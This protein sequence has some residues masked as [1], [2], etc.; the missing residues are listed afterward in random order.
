MIFTGFSRAVESAD[1][2]ARVSGLLET[3]EFEPS[4]PVKAGKL[5]FTIEKKHYQAARDSAFAAL[6]SAEADLQRAET[7]L[8]RVEQAIKTH[9]I[10][11]VDVDRAR[12]ARAMADSAVKSA[13]AALDQAE[14]DL[15][16][17][18]VVSP[19][20]GFVSRNLVDAGNVVGESGLTLLTRVNKLQPIH[21]YFNAPES[22]VLRYL[23]YMKEKEKRSDED[24]EYKG[25]ARVALA[26]DEGFPHKGEIDFIDNQVNPDTGTIEMRI[27]LENEDLVLF[28]GLFVRVKLSGMELP[29]AV[30][31]PETA[32]GTDLGGKYVLLVGENNI[33]EQRYVELGLPQDGGMV[34]VE[35]GLEGDET[36]IVNGLMFARPGLPVTP[37][38]PEQFEAMQSQAGGREKA[39][40]RG[41]AQG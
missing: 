25:E 17:T 13:Q 24:E 10:S 5:L 34:H 16:Y 40:S 33:V 37:L 19:I 8:K 41:G 26:T 36:V 22:L 4:T 39:G 30:L 32:V 9:A 18:R 23:A 2:V 21:V 35:K 38:T 27:R 31:I 11:E 14:L 20:N 15:S 7:E 28:P 6:K 1:V 12:A 29:G 3:V